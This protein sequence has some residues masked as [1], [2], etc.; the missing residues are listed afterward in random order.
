[1]TARDVSID[2][3]YSRIVTPGVELGQIDQI[4][5]YVLNHPCCTR[6]QIAAAHTGALNQEAR[7]SARVKAA[8]DCGLI[9]ES[10]SPIKDEVTG[11]EA[12]PLYPVEKQQ[13]FFGE[14]NPAPNSAAPIS[15]A[16][17]KTFQI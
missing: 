14:Q 5:L 4:V 10:P 1:M 3:Y 13:D 16:R 9:V 2:A 7:V 17:W 8:L 15:I 12:Y 11:A 6:R